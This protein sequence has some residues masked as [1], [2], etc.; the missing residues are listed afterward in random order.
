MRPRVASARWASR[1]LVVWQEQD[2]LFGPGSI[3]YAAVHAS[4]G[5]VISGGTISGGGKDSQPEVASTTATNNDV[6]VVFRRAGEG[7]RGVRVDVPASGLPAVVGSVMTISSGANDHSP[8]IA[9]AS[10]TR[11]VIAWVHPGVPFPRPGPDEILA[12]AFLGDLTPYGGEYT[13]YSSGT[14]DPANP[15]LDG[16]GTRFLIAWDARESTSTQLRDVWCRMLEVTTSVGPRGNAVKAPGVAANQSDDDHEPAVSLLRRSSLGSKFLLAW[17]DGG[18]G[19]TPD[20]LIAVMPIDPEGCFPCGPYGVIPGTSTVDFGAAIA[21]R[22]QMGEVL[23]ECMIAFTSADRTPPFDPDI[24]AHRF[25]A[26][27]VGGS[28]GNLGGQCGIGGT[29]T[30]SS[31]TAVGNSQFRIEL[32]GAAGAIGGVLIL[33][34]SPPANGT[35]DCGPCRV[36]VGLATL[37][38][39]SFDGTTGTA[40]VNQPLPCAAA[41]IGAQFEAQWLTVN[42]GPAPCP[43]APNISASNRLRIVLGE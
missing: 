20:S 24:W 35:V 30:V 4:S 8:T 13:V 41:L 12:R 27:D 1:F 19:T 6:F 3:G 11:R 39:N 22:S 31:L 42:I 34:T 32:T 9:D 36:L 2:S 14:L 37:P 23:D 21:S 15:S 28:T 10:S 29:T 5:A 16:D 40:Y 26:F 17:T 25:A 33:D 43:I 18:N 38:P 7:I